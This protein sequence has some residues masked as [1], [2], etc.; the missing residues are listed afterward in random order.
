MEPVLEELKNNAGF[1][2]PKVFSQK[3]LSFFKLA[4]II[5]NVLEIAI[6]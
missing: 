3:L 6:P 4:Y 1:K 5:I 2:K